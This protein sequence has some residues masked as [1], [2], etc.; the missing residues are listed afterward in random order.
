MRPILGNA[1]LHSRRFE[2]PPVRRPAYGI[3]N[4]LPVGRV[5]SDTSLVWSEVAPGA[6]LHALVVLRDVQIDQAVFPE[7]PHHLRTALGKVS[8]FRERIIL[9]DPDRRMRPNR[10]RGVRAA[11]PSG[12]GFGPLDVARAE[13]I[14]AI[15]IALKFIGHRPHEQVRTVLVT[16]HQ[17]IDPKVLMLSHWP[18][19]L[20][21]ARLHSRK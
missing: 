10:M 13:A 5:I 3:I 8:V 14:L 18:K 16:L 1:V 9:G 6:R 21:L 15:R 20:L 11:N 19:A 4:P 17:C 7:R 2:V 12:D